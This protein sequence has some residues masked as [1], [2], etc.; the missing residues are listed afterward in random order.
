MMYNY[1]EYITIKATE[2]S[3]G[4]L[5]DEA[6]GEVFASGS[7]AATLAR[8]PETTVGL[9]LGAWTPKFFRITRTSR[10]YFAYMIHGKM[11]RTNCERL[12]Y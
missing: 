10:F 5:V 9:H 4:V 3:K 12:I 1:Q 6:D 7:T 2:M 8:A 11:C